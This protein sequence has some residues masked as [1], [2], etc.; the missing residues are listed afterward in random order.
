MPHAPEASATASR[1]R[2]EDG[3]PGRAARAPPSGG[4]GPRTASSAPRHHPR[5]PRAPQSPHTNTAAPFKREAARLAAG[6]ANQGGRCITPA[7]GRAAIGVRGGAARGGFRN[8][9]SA[10]LRA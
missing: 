8:R 4:A 5:P 2:R 10:A 1:P 7:G 9:R 6:T 3:A